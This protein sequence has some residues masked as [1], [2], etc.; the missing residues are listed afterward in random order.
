MRIEVGRGSLGGIRG[1]LLRGFLLR[2]L[3][4]GRGALGVSHRLGGGVTTL[5]GRLRRGLV[6]LLTLA[7]R[8]LQPRETLGDAHVLRRRAD[9][10][11]AERATV[12]LD[13][14]VRLHRL[15]RLVVRADGDISRAFTAA[16]RAVVDTSFEHAADLSEEF[17]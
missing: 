9:D 8:L 12:E 3:L 1:F 4:L 16:I 6:V 7:E 14:I 2:R 5:R 10:G 13:A 11:D 17:L 15:E